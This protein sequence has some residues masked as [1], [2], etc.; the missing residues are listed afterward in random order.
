[1]AQV[2]SAYAMDTDSVPPSRKL[3]LSEL[4]EECISVVL[5][6]L[7]LAA[8]SLCAAT[9]SS[10]NTVIALD[11]IWRSLC[12]A[13]PAL[14]NFAAHAAH[15]ELSPANSCRSWRQV[16]KCITH[17]PRLPEAL[18]LPDPDNWGEVRSGGPQVVYYSGRIGKDR[19]VKTLEPWV[20]CYRKRPRKRPTETGFN[21]FSRHLNLNLARAQEHM[22]NM[23]SVSPDKARKLE[24]MIII[25]AQRGKLGG[26]VDEKT[27]SQM[28]EMG[29]RASEE[30]ESE[31]KEQ[32]AKADCL[33]D[34][35]QSDCSQ[36]RALLRLY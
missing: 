24:E 4:P 9:C 32:A 34:G 16:A 2:E 29:Y 5:A 3:L 21:V 25:L 19:V 8:V 23:E 13:M 26:G 35:S 33:A 15:L 10:L 31:Y 12:L 18:Q 1:M 7:P 27:L 17:A 20:V 11:S 30:W 14:E 6:Q 22:L 28:L 36:A